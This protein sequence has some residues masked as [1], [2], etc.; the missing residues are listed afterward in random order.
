MTRAAVGLGSNLGDRLAHLRRAISGLS[1]LG[2][3]ESVSSLYETAPVGGP[4]Q[5]D[6]LNAV[7]VLETHLQPGPFLER[8][9]ELER[10]SGRRQALRWGPR[11]LDLDILIFGDRTVEEAGLTIPHP[12]LTQRRFALEPLVEAWPEVRLPGGILLVDMLADLSDQELRR[13][14]DPSWAWADKPA[15]GRRGRAGHS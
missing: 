15:P 10:A 12:R 13:V 6:Y 4:P 3:V 9:G 7:V 8:L 5:A 2:V 1:R 14:A 11:P